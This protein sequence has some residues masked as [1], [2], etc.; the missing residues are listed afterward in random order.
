MLAGPRRQASLG[1]SKHAQ[2]CIRHTQPMGGRAKAMG[3]MTATGGRSAA[4]GGSSP[5]NSSAG[6]CIWH[7][8]AGV[9]FSMDGVC[10]CGQLRWLLGLIL[11]LQGLRAA[12]TCLGWRCCRPPVRWGL[13]RAS[14]CRP[15][16][17][18]EPASH[19]QPCAGCVQGDSS[20][21]PSTTLYPQLVSVHTSIA[22]QSSLA[23]GETAELLS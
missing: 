9:V 10:L 23:G 14:L 20:S 16:C 8:E 18:N 3:G 17:I 13:R 19:L 5:K 15:A 4:H 11:G 1:G 12:C 6:A 7:G 21:C 22:S 2:R